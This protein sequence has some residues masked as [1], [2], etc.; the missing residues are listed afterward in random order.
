MAQ[1]L[2]KEV[3]PKR[4]DGSMGEEIPFSAMFDYV[5]DYET[6]YTLK[7]FF[8]HYMDFMQNADFI[9]YGVKA[10]ENSHVRLWID[11]SKPNL[12]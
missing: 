2:L 1:N 5:F 6:K 8:K 3:K 12:P 10:P 9:Y 11:T 4:D 7:H